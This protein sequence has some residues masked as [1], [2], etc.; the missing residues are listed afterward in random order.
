MNRRHGIAVGREGFTLI[1]LLVVITIIGILVGLLLP[2]INSA[3][4]AAR[5][6]QCANNIRQLGLALNNFHSAKGKFPAS[7]T[8]MVNGKLDVSQIQTPSTS[9]VF[10]NWVIDI[11]PFIEGRTIQLT[12]NTNLAIS[13]AANKMPRAINLAIMLCP[14]DSYNVVPFSGSGSGSTSFLGD[15]WGRGNYAANAALGK[16]TVSH[17]AGHDAATLQVWGSRYI[18]G[19]MGANVS[20]KLKDIRD[21]ASKTIMLGEM[22]AGL[23]SYDCRGVW[24][25]SGG[26]SALWAHGYIGDDGGPNAIAY[27]ADDMLSCTDVQNALGG[28]VAVAKLGMPCAPGGKANW[29]QTARS[30]HSSGVNTCFVDNSVRFINDYIDVGFDGS[31][32]KLGTWDKLVLS[33]DGQGINAVNY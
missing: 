21:G 22:R 16:M 1:E 18:R 30:M 11:L 9:G 15:N 4:E 31:P 23:T 17:E 25:M 27:E 6:T 33:D 8:W 19:V 13:N 28:L 32:P 29:Q 3:R 20:C 7:S 5:R 26:P 12:F 2:A 14:T 10:K 24:A